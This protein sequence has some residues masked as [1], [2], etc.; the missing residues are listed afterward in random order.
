MNTRHLY[1]WAWLIFVAGVTY[2]S[3][4]DCKSLPFPSRFIYGGIVFGLLDMFAG[5]QEELAA[6]TAI[7]FVIATYLGKGWTINCQ[8]PTTSQPQTASFTS[9]SW[10]QSQPPSYGQ[11]V[12][13]NPSQVAPQ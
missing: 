9:S 12:T 7:G 5:F 4:K 8:Y 6:V 10:E 3:L 13:G 2:Y 1:L 11:F